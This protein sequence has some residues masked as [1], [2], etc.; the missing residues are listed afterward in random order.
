MVIRGARRT[1]M[2]LQLL[3]QQERSPFRLRLQPELP[4]LRL[5]LR[6]LEHPPLPLPLPQEPLPLQL[7]LQQEPSLLQLPLRLSGHP[8]LQLQ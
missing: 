7:P 6:L 2:L 5:L 1:V 4:L 8:P 3:T